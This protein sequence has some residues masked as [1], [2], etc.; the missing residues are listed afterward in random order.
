VEITVAN[1]GKSPARD[2]KILGVVGPAAETPGVESVN[3][4]A[5]RNYPS[6][7][8]APGAPPILVIVT[9]PPLGESEELAIRSNANALYT[10]GEIR[11]V[12]IFN[13][14]QTTGFCFSIRQKDIKPEGGSVMTACETGN[15]AH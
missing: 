3:F 14:N 11:Y 12:D 8:L 5:V 2:V 7:V 13:R 9:R 4:G 1:S 10:W 15:Y 6:A